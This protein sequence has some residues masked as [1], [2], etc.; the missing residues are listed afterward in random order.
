[1]NEICPCGGE[2]KEIARKWIKG[3]EYIV[4]VCQACGYEIMELV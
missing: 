4:M 3:L 2:Y 1:M